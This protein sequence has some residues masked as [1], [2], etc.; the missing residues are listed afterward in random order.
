MGLAWA[1]LPVQ[2]QLGGLGLGSPLG[3]TVNN[4]PMNGGQQRS[5]IGNSRL[6]ISNGI[7]NGTIGLSPNPTLP[8]NTLTPISGATSPV[9]G[10]FGNPG[11][12]PGGGGVGGGGYNAAPLDGG[13]IIL[14]MLGLGIFLQ[15][16]L[17]EYKKNTHASQ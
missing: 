14:I 6:Q 10:T 3:G 7:S 17:R 1:T 9:M 12:G 8:G 5:T 13:V 2:A 15:I 16:R 11:G 4:L